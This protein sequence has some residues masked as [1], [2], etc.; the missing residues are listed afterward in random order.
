VNLRNEVAVDTFEAGYKFSRRRNHGFTFSPDVIAGGGGKIAKDGGG[1]RNTAVTFLS[2]PFS[3]IFPFY[4]CEYTAE[5][6][7]GFENAKVIDAV[8]PGKI[9]KDKRKYDLFTSPALSFH[10][11]MSGDAF[12]HIKDTRQIKIYRQTCKGGPCGFSFFFILVR[13]NALCHNR[14]TSLV[15]DLV[16]VPYSI[17]LIVQRQ[18]GFLF[19]FGGGLRCSWQALS[20]AE[21]EKVSLMRVTPSL[22]TRICRPI[23]RRFCASSMDTA[24][25]LPGLRYG[26]YIT[27]RYIREP[28]PVFFSNDHL[29]PHGADNRQ[30]FHLSPSVPPGKAILGEGTHVSSLAD[31]APA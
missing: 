8:T 22:G 1:G 31:I 12:T 27:A 29:V 6:F 28:L 19:I 11:K 21:T 14:F 25:S 9:E 17:M 16:L 5:A 24:L 30:R 3:R 7:I 13:E 26:I 15:I 10:G 18:R 2:P 23:L 20:L 4:V